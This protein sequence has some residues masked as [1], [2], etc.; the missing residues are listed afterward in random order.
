MKT[1]FLNS[2]ILGFCIIA[3]ASCSTSKNITNARSY[4]KLGIVQQS[5]VQVHKEEVVNNAPKE[6]WAAPNAKLSHPCLTDRQAFRAENLAAPKVGPPARKLKAFA[7]KNLSFHIERNAEI[8]SGSP[9]SQANNEPSDDL[10]LASIASL[11]AS[12][13]GF[14]FIGPSLGICFFFWILG[15]VL[16]II[17]LSSGSKLKGL[18]ILAIVVGAMSLL[19]VY[20]I[21]V[22]FASMSFNLM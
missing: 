7:S 22:V 6:R 19:M 1:R 21:S 9:V 10:G 15:I 11:L 12:V 4:K 5:N 18:A 17:A 2:L 20:A 13:L 8:A 3:L 16:G 14:F